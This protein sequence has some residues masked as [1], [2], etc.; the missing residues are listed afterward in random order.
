M[1][2]DYGGD[3][4]RGNDIVRHSAKAEK[5]ERGVSLVPTIVSAINTAKNTPNAP[6]GLSGLLD[7]LAY[8]F[9]AV[10]LLGA[11]AW[12]GGQG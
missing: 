10:I 7:V 8:V 4:L 6:T 1:R 11:V 12:I 5:T 9:V 2:R 3:T